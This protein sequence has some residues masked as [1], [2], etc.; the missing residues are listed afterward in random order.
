MAPSINAHEP[1]AGLDM[2]WPARISAKCMTRFFQLCCRPRQRLADSDSHHVF[3]FPQRLSG[4]RGY[5]AAK[6]TLATATIE[7]TGARELHT[8][9]LLCGMMKVGNTLATER[10]PLVKFKES[11]G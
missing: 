1:P 2:Q 4:G 9:A 8:I 11:T 7:L 10:E 3:H 6:I 5:A